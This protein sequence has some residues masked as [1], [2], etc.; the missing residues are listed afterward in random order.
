MDGAVC[1][2]EGTGVG[3]QN[4]PCVRRRAYGRRGKN[5]QI[6]DQTF[7]AACIAGDGN[8]AAIAA[9]LGIDRKVVTRRIQDDPELNALYGDGKAEPEIGTPKEM[10]LMNRSPD[11]LPEHVAQEIG[12]VSEE[13]M[14]QYYTALRA[15][16]VSE[17]RLAKLKSLDGLA[18]DWAT[19]VSISLRGHHQSYD[20]QLHNL[21]EVAESIKEKLDSG[22][23]NAEEYSYLSKVY[24]ECVKEA[25]KGVGMML[26]LTE[27]LVR[28]IGASKNDGAP[29]KATAGWGPMKKVRPATN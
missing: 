14:E 13:D 5:N 1:E 17:K 19:H 28:M 21:A 3:S 29:A 18:K 6:T 26:T 25:G 23:L 8:R 12:S 15:Y 16:G 24:V 10:A 4:P 20:G 22:D 9:A 7:R 2:E 11:D 27:A